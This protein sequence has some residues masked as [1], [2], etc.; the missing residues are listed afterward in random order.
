MQNILENKNSS[1]DI[2]DISHYVQLIMNNWVKISLFSFMVTALAILLVLQLTPKYSATATLLIEAQEKKAV[3]I[4][5]VVGIDSTQKEYYQTQ[6][7]ILKS[8][9]IA[10]K[11]IEKLDL[12]NN[13]EFYPKSSNDKSLL[14]QIKEIPFIQ[15]LLINNNESSEQNHDES[16]RQTIL[17]VFKKNLIIAP[18]RNT[19]LVKISFTSTDPNLAAEIANAIGYAYIESNLESRL[20]A[21]EYAS[22]WIS[23]RLSD[24][25]SQLERSEQALNNFLVK[26]KLIDDSGIQSLASQELTTLTER[27]AEVR[28]ERIATESAYTALVSADDGDVASIS[29]IPMISSH[30]QVIEIRKA[31]IAVVNEAKELSKRY[32][33][34]HD[35]MRAVQAKLDSI[36]EQAKG[37]TQKLISGIGKELRAL[38][39]QEQLLEQ[40]ISDKKEQFQDITIKRAKFE[41]L[42]REV[43]TNRSLL[44][45]FLT[46]QKET[47]A[48]QDFAAANARFTD[49]ALVPLF[50]T[51]P[52]KK[53]I[54]ILSLIISLVAS[55][56][57]IV[58]IDSMK[59]T[60]ET[61]K[62]FEDKFGL[63]P[64]G[65]IPLLKQRWLNKKP[66][67]NKIL[68]DE[69]LF[70]FGESI[71]SIRTSVTLNSDENKILAITSSN[72]SEG[73][74]TLAINIAMAFAALEK[75]IIVDCDLRKSSV[76][77]RFQLKKY[78]QGL[79]NNI[80]L[81][82]ELSDCVYVDEVSGL[83]ILPAGMHAN[84]SQ[85]L[86]SSHKFKSLINE[87]ETKFDRIIIDTPPC[88]PVSDALII[89]K[90]ADSMLL[91]VKANETKQKSI[92]RTLSK[93]LSHEIKIEGV[94]VNQVSS[95]ALSDEYGYEY[96]KYYSYDN[97]S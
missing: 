60:I 83:T 38:R 67:D 13:E 90:L 41:S 80:L 56:I 78:Q 29:A 10:E 17:G 94:V 27:V 96:G 39:K 54:V 8:N 42:Q 70:S 23:G 33:P 21:T 47:N 43:A 50:P 84:N 6:F 20:V 49:K 61:A 89:G 92:E 86:L 72:A 79:T 52:K 65:S 77:E 35:K 57:L 58:I 30:P 40:E 18:V 37:I 9:Q 45:V 25:R 64:L 36:E 75:T 76:A 55:V 11:V 28:D 74:T 87:L 48:T 3:S 69:K 4:E 91:V 59:N 51:S 73:K 85:E 93:L 2:V 63:I 5:E 97:V 66:L 71:R 46:R 88:I 81:G 26:E 12:K 53:M 95:K 14:D 62:S 15:S 44:N 34:R 1:E 82:N 19:Q 7:E 31:E 24:L 68:H 16:I 22:S 32:G